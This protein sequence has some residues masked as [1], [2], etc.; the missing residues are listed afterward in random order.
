MESAGLQPQTPP[1]RLPSLE[2]QR[3]AERVARDGL[4]RWLGIAVPDRAQLFAPL[5]APHVDLRQGDVGA[6]FHDDYRHFLSIA[7]GCRLG[8]VVVLGARDARGTSDGS[9][10]VI[11]WDGDYAGDFVLSMDIRGGDGR[12]WRTDTGARG[13]TARCLDLDLPKPS[14]L[15]GLLTPSGL[16]PDGPEDACPRGDGASAR[17]PG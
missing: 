5:P 1:L 15:R 12:L 14:Y 16:V 17:W 7:D 11:A 6:V 10:V 3:A 2:D 13:A 4:S 8:P 9:G